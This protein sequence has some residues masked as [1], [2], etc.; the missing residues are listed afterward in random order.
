MK[1][2]N[3][4]GRDSV[5]LLVLK[6]SIPFMFAQFV[7]VLYSIVDRIYI[8][9]IPV[10]GGDSLAGAGVCAPIITLLS[11]FAALIGIGGSVTFSVKLGAG[12]KKS[13]QRILANSFS[14]LLIFS[15]VLTVVFLMIKDFLLNWFGA[16]EVTFP[17]AN[18]Y[19]TIYTLG[20]FFALVSMGMNY[21]VTAQGFP[22]LGMAT[23]LIGA[24]VN[25][26]LDPIFIF[27][28]DM[29]IA[30]A[31]VATVIAQLSSCIFVLLTLHSKKMQIPIHLVKPEWEIGKRICKIGFSPFLILATDSVII[32]AL[33]AV[34]QYY[35][36]ESQGDTLIT[37]ATIVQSYMLLITSP[38]LGI[39]GGSQPLISFNYGANKPDRIRKTVKWVLVLCITF[40]TV[41][42]LV[43]RIL[44][45]YFVQ[46]F[47][48]NARYREL[49][50]WGIQVFTL[51]V[52]PLSLQYVFVDALTAL[53]MTRLSLSLSLFRKIVYF[54]MTCV[55]PIVFAAK[56]AFYAE[57]LADGAAACLTSLVFFVIYRKYLKGE[58]WERYGC[59]EGWNIKKIRKQEENAMLQTGTKA[60]EFTLP[61]QNG[62][63][64]SLKDYRG[65]R[66]LLYFYPRDNTPGCTKQA[67]GYSE[68]YPQFEEKGVVILGISKDS[69]ASHKRFEE[70]Q[71]LTITL[72]SDTELEVIQAYDVW[73]EKK[74]YG[75]VSMGVV[76]TT[77][78]IDEEGVII[79]ANDKV[80]AAEDPEKML[81]EIS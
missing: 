58:G 5:P 16:S 39:T 20:T 29:D 65:K 55:L 64:H 71:G 18:T 10:I 8:G 33:N 80:K 56:S 36:G 14:M 32:I 26:V 13:A 68:R 49:S 30:G 11:S 62:E 15:A 45:Q 41:M 53:G 63:L 31:A 72:L 34:L 46:I 3:D 43:S 12:D 81:A 38:M 37:A 66:V 57:P 9:N 21:F 42:F 23:T 25:I 48:D 6:T 2:T 4:F 77:Y 76:R 73:K 44:P 59:K 7:N 70:K 50:I 28:F 61:D 60:P 47:T 17:Y 78:L 51:M 19:L 22:F 24:V 69:V 27:V 52:I 1:K 40:T 74:N 67:C 75:K 35:G 79:Q 54:V